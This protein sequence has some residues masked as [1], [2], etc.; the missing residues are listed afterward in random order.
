MYANYAVIPVDVVPPPVNVDHLRRFVQN[1]CESCAFS[2]NVIRYVL[3]SARKPLVGNHMIEHSIRHRQIEMKDVDTYHWDPC[4][5]EAFSDLTCWFEAL[6]FKRL[7]E[8][9][10]VTQTDD[11]PD[12]MDIYGMENSVSYFAKFSVIEPRN[13][14]IVICDP[15]DEDARCNSFYVTST[16]G[17]NRDYVKFPPDTHTIA[18]SSSICYH[19]ATHH[20]GHYKTTAVVHGVLDTERHMA[21]LAKSLKK[22]GDFAIRYEEARPVDGPG[23]IFPY[24]G[25]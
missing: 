3:F 20:K 19:G 22:Y 9:D 15:A 25:V 8:I 2:D 10:L 17:G 18:T 7:N 13:Y 23:A 5:A 12:H 21:L 6:P 24:P 16:H 1:N 11:I 14:R 4:F